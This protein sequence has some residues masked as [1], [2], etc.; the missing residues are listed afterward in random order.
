MY[1]LKYKIQKNVFKIIFM[2]VLGPKTCL[3]AFIKKNN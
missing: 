3:G 2:D 1:E